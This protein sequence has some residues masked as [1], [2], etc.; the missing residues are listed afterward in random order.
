MLIASTFFAFIE[1]KVYRIRQ[2]K[3]LKSRLKNEF[4]ETRSRP[5]AFQ[6]LPYF[7]RYSHTYT[8]RQ[9]S[10]ENS[11]YSYALDQG[12]FGEKSSRFSERT[13]Y[14]KEG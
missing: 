9:V 5:R 3:N 10:F 11:A 7:Q 13:K 8:K 6:S 2:R 12:F 1:Q 4:S 14:E